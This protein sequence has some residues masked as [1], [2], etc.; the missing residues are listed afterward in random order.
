MAPIKPDNVFSTASLC[1]R[2]AKAEKCAFVIIEVDY[3]HGLDATLEAFPSLDPDVVDPSDCD[4]VVM[5]FEDAS[6]ARE[7]F[8][9]LS[10]DLAAA[11]ARLPGAV[12]AGIRYVGPLK[13]G[14]VIVTTNTASLRP[15][16]VFV[17]DELVGEGPMPGDP[18]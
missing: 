14:T 18:A 5:R 9:R 3:H 12:D 11:Q 7:A 4:A 15:M 16:H 10:R 8:T 6:V 2:V 13:C 1:G 17:A